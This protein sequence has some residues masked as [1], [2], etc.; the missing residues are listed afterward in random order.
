MMAFL[1]MLPMVFVY[2]WRNRALVSFWLQHCM[3][4]EHRLSQAAAATTDSEAIALQYLD[5]G[6][7]E[8][9]A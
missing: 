2:K 3:S 8:V 7:S 4:C 6:S 5:E 9:V 1:A